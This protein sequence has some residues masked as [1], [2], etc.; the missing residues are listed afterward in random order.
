MVDSHKRIIIDFELAFDVWSLLFC[1]ARQ[2]IMNTKSVSLSNRDYIHIINKPVSLGVQSLQKTYGLSDNERQE[3]VSIFNKH[4]MSIKPWIPY[5]QFIQEL[6]RCNYKVYLRPHIEDEYIRQLQK[7]I[8]VPL[9]P[10]HEVFSGT[11]LV[12]T[13]YNDENSITVKARNIDNI[14][15]F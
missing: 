9:I 6:V 14:S 15:E 5:Q 7:L 11:D 4:V 13:S 2:T 8:K 1:V 10:Q 12:L 3:I